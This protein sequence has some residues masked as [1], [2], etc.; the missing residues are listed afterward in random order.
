MKVQDTYH[1]P[2]ILDLPGA[3][4]RVFHP[5]LSPEEYERR[6]KL[7]HDAAV[8]VLKAK[9]RNKSNGR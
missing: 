7:I 1:E 6:M 2:I 3:K 9:E 4:V 8:D 5:I